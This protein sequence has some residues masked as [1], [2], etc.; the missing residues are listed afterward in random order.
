[1][2]GN[3]AALESGE[4][5]ECR[6][7]AEL[8][9]A[10]GMRIFESRLSRED[11][12]PDVL[13]ERMNFL[14]KNSLRLAFV[15]M[16]PEKIQCRSAFD[17]EGASAFFL[18]AVPHTV[19]VCPKFIWP[20]ALTLFFTLLILL[21]LRIYPKMPEELRSAPFWLLILSVLGLLGGRSLW[22]CGVM[23]AVSILWIADRF[24]KRFTE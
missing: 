1:M 8:L 23:L 4:L 3:E 18:D 7:S 6:R 21:G 5:E 14:Q 17:S 11:L 13:E 2:G 12:M 19:S 16:L 22:I 15:R 9:F 24:R 10:D 20:A